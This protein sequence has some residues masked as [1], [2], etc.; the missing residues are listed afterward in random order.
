MVI[1]F[2]S[3]C[4]DLILS[5]WSETHLSVKNSNI[6]NK[7]VDKSSFFSEPYILCEHNGWAVQTCLTI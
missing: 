4:I 3:I 6:L 7:S 1:K 5:L 2:L